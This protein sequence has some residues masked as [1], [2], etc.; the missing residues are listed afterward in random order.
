MASMS[1]KSDDLV[2]L[3]L[4]AG[5]KM[6]KDDDAESKGWRDLHVA[7]ASNRIDEIVNLIA[8]RGAAA[9]DRRDKE[10]RTPLMLAAEKGYEGCVRMLAGAGADM[11]A[12]SKD[13]RTGLYRAVENGDRRMVE[14]LIELGA[15]PTIGVGDRGHSALDVARDRGYKEVVDILEQGEIVMTAVRH[16]DS[17]HL[18]R[19]LKRGASTSW[20]DQ[21]GWT[22]L[23]VA[24]IKGHKDIVKLLLEFVLDLEC[25]DNEGHTPLHLAVEGGCVEIVEALADRKANLSAK[26]KKGATPLYMA[27]VME[28]DDI[29]KFLSERGACK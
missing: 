15:D 6:E 9:L 21:Y 25:R 17:S 13:G 29:Y 18:I 4:D 10:G 12:S 27:E 2:S 7:A 28:Y 8:G 20:C 3:L 19:L 1:G 24:A 5:L 11:D 22:A 23:H 16:G 26:S 14:V